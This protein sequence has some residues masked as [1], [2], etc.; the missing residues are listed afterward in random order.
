MSFLKVDDLIL[1]FIRLFYINM[2]SKNMKILDKTINIKVNK[3]NII[4][5]VIVNCTKSHKVGVNAHFLTLN[6]FL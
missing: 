2:R 5:N 3:Q 4:N 6:I 1:Q